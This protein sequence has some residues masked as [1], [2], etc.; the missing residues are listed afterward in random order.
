LDTARTLLSCVEDIGID[1]AEK[2]KICQINKNSDIKVSGVQAIPYPKARR[3][4]SF[5][6]PNERISTPAMAP[7]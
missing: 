7:V 3:I 6:L 2:K 1:A 4:K 5:P